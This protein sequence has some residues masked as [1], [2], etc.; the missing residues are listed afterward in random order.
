MGLQ[1]VKS[2]CIIVDPLAYLVTIKKL[3]EM[4]T[5]PT[6]TKRLETL[7]KRFSGLLKNIIKTF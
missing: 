4:S 5:Y 1:K 7:R 2:P 3:I 6:N